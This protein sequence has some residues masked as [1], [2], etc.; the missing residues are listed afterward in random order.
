MGN[1]DISFALREYQNW[2]A[3]NYVP[4]TPVVYLNGYPIPKQYS[5]SDMESFVIDLS[6]ILTQSTVKN[7]EHE[8]VVDFSW[9]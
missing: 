4:H 6:E 8:K 9:Q 3:K 5:L 7:K 1:T 2:A